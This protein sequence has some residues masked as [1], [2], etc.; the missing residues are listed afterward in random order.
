MG[1]AGGP[2]LSI[3][4]PVLDEA[5]GIAAALAPLQ[6]LRQAGVEVI[7]V[8]GGSRDATPTLAAPLADR[9]LAAPRGRGS[10]MNAGAAAARGTALL[11]LHA[12]TR[13]P[14][15]AVDAIAA[16]VA[17][18]ACWGRFDVDIEGR[19]AGLGMVATMMNLRSRLT[20]IATGDQA[21]FVTRAAFEQV[22]GFPD[23]P[24]MEDIVLSGRLR[25]LAR[26][27]CLRLR[28]VTSGRRWEKS[29]LWRTIL[30]M[31]RLR[32]RF[33]LGADPQALAREYGYVPR[34]AAI[35]I[36]ILA[37]APLAGLAKTRLI[38]RLGAAGAAA[39]QAALLRRTVATAQAAGLGP[40][41]LWCAPDCSHPAFAALAG[42]APL[43]L[44]AQPAGDLGVR[45]QAA[46]GAT[47]APVAGTLVIG[48]DCP[49]L[50]PALLRE[51][52]A[53]L[54]ENEATLI[55]A[56]DGGYV[57]IGLRRP[58]PRVFAD[59]DWSTPAVAAQTRARFAEL[60]WRWHEFAPLWDVDHAADFARLQR[61]DPAL[62]AAA[63]SPPGACHA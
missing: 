60:A 52:A 39:L 13:L 56:E 7:V 18:G 22:G 51:A 26:P 6:P 48:T 53:A 21:I 15:G 32:L 37:K 17:A 55:P 62:A 2:W 33:F 45:M 28:V 36:A 54:R 12:D 63:L 4:V 35:A 61:H 31:W 44:A 24:L 42:A 34:E 29:G 1:A 8:D 5:A 58:E 41:T 11:F 16:A 40:V 43:Q 19:L 9:A 59:I 46:V 10:Q 57:L 30:A 50:T 49:A 20:G 23:L 47:S 3:V 25:R 38:P 27:A 14:A